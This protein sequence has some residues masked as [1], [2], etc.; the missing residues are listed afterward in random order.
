M[1]DKSAYNRIEIPDN[2]DAAV[3][4]AV[5]EGLSRRRGARVLRGF[6]KA[7]AVAALFT[8]CVVSALNLS[9]AFAAAAC[10]LPV[11][12]GLC[13][14]LLFR[15][16]HAAD[17]I[18]YIDVQIPQIETADNS[19]LEARV[20][21]EIR[22]RVQACMNAGEVRA[23]EYYDA[24]LETGGDPEDFVPLGLTVTYETKYISQECVSFVVSQH[25]TRFAAYNSNFYYNIDLET[26][27]AI[28]LEN[29]FG[30][31]YR[32][33]VA[34]SIEASIA[35]WSEEQR[36]MLWD[37]LSIVDLISEDTSFYFNSDG[38]VVV[39]IEKYKA[40][41]GAAGELEFTIS[42]NP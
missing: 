8:I 2:L 19:E 37:D 14:V 36:S 41:C 4:E 40:A 11:V 34:E 27:A 26:G 24:F 39:V 9:P 7:G 6:K 29:W 35:G 15:E 3:Q 38:Q 10:E 25:E 32:E 22:S 18:R 28:T 1:I 31:H 30:P 16:Y 12:G 33:I 5:A 20:N 13:Q 42:T 21:Q 23:R 17:E